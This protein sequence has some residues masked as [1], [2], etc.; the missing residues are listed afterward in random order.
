[1]KALS[2]FLNEIK[3]EGGKGDKLKP[4]DVDQ[5]ELAVGIEVEYEHKEGDKEAAQDVALDHL[6]EDPHYYS[7][8][9]AAG[10]VDEEPAIELAKKYGWEIGSKDSEDEIDADILLDIPEL[11]DIEE[12]ITE[13]RMR[14]LK[15]REINSGK[16]VKQTTKELFGEN[17]THRQMVDKLF[18][19]FKREIRKKAREMNVNLSQ[20]R[21]WKITLRD[22]DNPK[23][24]T[25][26][27]GRK[28]NN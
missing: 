12:E 28:Q 2:D 9:I 27:L 8:L 23:A 15:P 16:V 24:N 1:M 26:V 14:K 18:V 20:V 25:S 6:A 3:I 5:E 10:L 21:T 4:E 13:G 11:E 17:G 7:E 22:L 19:I